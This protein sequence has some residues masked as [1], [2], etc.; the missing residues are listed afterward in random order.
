MTEKKRREFV[1]KIAV[2]GGAGVGKS[3]LINRY[4]DRKFDEDYKPTLGASIIAKDISH[5]Q[6]EQRYYCFGKVGEEI[7]TVRFIYRSN[8]IHIIGAGYW[9]KGRKLYENKNQKD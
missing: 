1:F 9:R 6:E 3:S 7:I 5:S 2:L 8:V 4:V